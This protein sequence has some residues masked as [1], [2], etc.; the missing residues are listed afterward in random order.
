MAHDLEKRQAAENIWLHYFNQE[1]H[2]HSLISTLQRNKMALKI[3]SRKPPIKEIQ[4]KKSAPR[5]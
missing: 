5:Q 4:F 3:E 1:L 2:K